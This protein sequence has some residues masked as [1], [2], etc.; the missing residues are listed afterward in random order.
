MAQR[1][2]TTDILNAYAAFEGEDVGTFTEAWDGYIAG[3]AEPCT[4]PDGLHGY[5]AGTCIHCGLSQLA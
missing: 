2:Y 5:E 1:I 4:S 3:D